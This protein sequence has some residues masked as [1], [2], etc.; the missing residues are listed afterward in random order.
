MKMKSLVWGCGLTL[1]FLLSCTV[2]AEVLN[3]KQCPPTLVSLICIRQ[4]KDV[5]SRSGCKCLYFKWHIYATSPKMVSVIFA[6][7]NRVQFL[8]KVQSMFLLL[9][10]FLQFH[11]KFWKYRASFKFSSC[12]SSP[13][14]QEQTA[15]RLKLSHQTHPVEFMWSSL[16]DLRLP[17][18]YHIKPDMLSL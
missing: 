8:L 16:L 14:S 9:A 7:T 1:V 11:I 18:R 17:S 2:L 4:E 10:V 5:L 12:S 13:C 3:E 6:R 15:P